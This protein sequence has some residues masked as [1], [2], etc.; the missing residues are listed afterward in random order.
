MKDF[1]KEY[2]DKDGDLVRKNSK[3]EYHS[4]YS[5]AI[6]FSDGDK[7]WLQNDKFHRLDGPAVD[8]TDGYKEWWYE[9]EWYGSSNNGYT[10]E[11]FIKDF[12]ILHSNSL[13]KDYQKF[14]A[15]LYQYCG[16][17]DNIDTKILD[18]LSAGSRGIP[19]PHKSIF[20]KGKGKK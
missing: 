9:D 19:L 15:E 3:G 6:E 20:S 8:D 5:P 1:I 16:S 18:N 10:Q 14:F 7:R 2:I 12:K 11:Q 17:L 4:L 13:I